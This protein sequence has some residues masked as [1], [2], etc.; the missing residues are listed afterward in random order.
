MS[1]SIFVDYSHDDREPIIN[2][3]TFAAYLKQINALGKEY[4]INMKHEPLFQTILR[5][6]DVLKADVVVNQPETE[7]DETGEDT[8]AN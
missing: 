1:F 2:K 6:P 8:D 3:D 7:D 4:K 5:M